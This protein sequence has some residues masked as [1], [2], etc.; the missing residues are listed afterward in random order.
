MAAVVAVGQRQVY[1]LVKTHFHSPSYKGDDGFS[2]VVYGIFYILY[3]AAV[4]QVPKTLFK[5]LLFYGGYVLGNV[6]VEG[7][8]DVGSVGNFRDNAVDF[9]ELLCLQTAEAF[10]GSAVDGVVYVVGFFKFV[11]FL[12]I[13]SIT[14]KAKAPSS[15]RN[16]LL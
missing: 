9:P 6:A 12:F 10:G 2:V 14:S 7:V 15:T 16:F 5:V 11:Y 1:A 3:F 4:K 8:A 13:Y